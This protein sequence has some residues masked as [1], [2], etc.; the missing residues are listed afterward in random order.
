MRFTLGPKAHPYIML[1]QGPIILFMM[2]AKQLW[3][4]VDVRSRGGIGCDHFAGCMCM[5]HSSFSYGMNV[6]GYYKK[7]YV[8]NDFADSRL[9][10]H[11]HFLIGPFTLFDGFLACSSILVLD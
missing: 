4:C 3:S 11:F 9:N 10:L 5:G 2:W 7:L 1:T 8:H 6:L